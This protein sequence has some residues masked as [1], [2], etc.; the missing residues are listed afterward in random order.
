MQMVEFILL[1]IFVVLFFHV[2]FGKTVPDVSLNAVANLGYA[3]GRWG[4]PV[5]PGDTLSTVSTVIGKRETGVIKKFVEYAKGVE[6]R[7]E[8]K[9]KKSSLHVE[10]NCV[11]TEF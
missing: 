8:K 6:K 9:Q 4:V 1:A 2:V 7:C 11:M 5:Y 10:R 3:D